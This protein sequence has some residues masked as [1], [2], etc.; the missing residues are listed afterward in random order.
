VKQTTSDKQ[1]QTFLS[2][3]SLSGRTL[4]QRLVITLQFFGEN[5]LANHASAC[6][7][8]FLLSA[9]PVL[10]LLSFLLFSA[11][12]SVTGGADSAQGGAALTQLLAGI[13]LLSGVLDKDWLARELSSIAESGM[14]LRGIA[15]LVSAVGI[16]WAGR[17]FALSMQRGLKVVFTGTRKR[18]PLFELVIVCF[19]E[20]AVLTGALLMILFSQTA[21]SLYDAFDFFPKTS[22][23]GSLLSLYNGPLVSFL[24]LAAVFY[25]VCR[26]LAA[27]GP[28]RA[29]AFWGS[30]CFAVSYTVF[31]RI[32]AAFLNQTRYNFLY[33]ALGSLIFLLVNVF[34]FFMFFFFCAQFARVIDSFDALLFLRLRQARINTGGKAVE[35]TLFYSEKGKLEK[36]LRAYPENTLIFS[37]GD[38]GS[39]VFYLL[40]GEVDIVMSDGNSGEQPVTLKEGAFF[41]EMGHLLSENRTASARTKT[42]VSALVLP[43][44]LFDETLQYD[45]SLDRVIMEHLSRRLKL[46]NEQYEALAS[47]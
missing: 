43:P 34:F 22:L 17:I 16:F 3:L 30:L 39:D 31:S 23:P 19:V 26:L 36:Y 12:S 38:E 10:M 8:G 5:S 41:G 13:P 32:L 35:H 40:E 20:L 47:Q 45:T 15:G 24:L 28:C 6:A 29:S 9:A 27:N 37:R 33:G 25:V 21:R 18:N 4:L 14:R 11:F 7:Y 44:C 46:R 42:A 2:R 1:R